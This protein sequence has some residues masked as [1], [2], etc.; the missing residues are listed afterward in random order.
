MAKSR[1]LLMGID[2]G[3]THCKVGLFAPDGAL[4]A[5]ASRPMQPRRDETGAAF[6]DSQDLW[7]AILDAA[8]EAAANAGPHRLTAVGVAG[9]AESGLLVDRHDG[10]PLTGIIPWFDTAA[11]PQAIR[12]AKEAGMQAG[13]VRSGIYPSFKCSLAKLLWLRETHNISFENAVW[14]SVPDWVVYRLT[15]AAATDYSLATRTFAFDINR[16]EWDAAF[17]RRFDLDPSLFPQAQTAGTVAGRISTNEYKR[18]G[19]PKGVPVAVCGHDHVAGAFAVGAVEPGTV[20]DSMG[21]AE[22][23]IGAAPRAPLDQAEFESGLTF[24]SHVA[25]DRNYWMG[26]LSTSGGSVEWLRGLLSDPALTY[27]A[28][29]ALV[30]SAP[31]R[32]TGLLYFPYLAGSGA[33]HSDPLARA[34]FIGISAQTTRAELAR[35]VLEGAA[36]ELEAVRLAAVRATG[37]SIRRIIAAGGGTRNRAWMQIKADVSGVQFEIPAVEETTLL[38]AALLAGLGSG[39]YA[40]EEEALTGPRRTPSRM[41][42]PNP[43]NRTLYQKLFA[44]GYQQLQEP[45]RR[46]YRYRFEES[47]L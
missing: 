21:T 30:E 8:G 28:F 45:L 41:V 14:L 13:F 15:G 36:F 27:D 47:I 31:D 25:R 20:F 42:E 35:A 5:A 4:A 6:F 11:N 10:R 46:F 7:R 44:N 37:Q 2:T 18:S 9:M 39:L 32:P 40:S 19:L 12:L 29:N 26:G 43:E 3:T 23:F 17:L 24:G 34:A 22:A 16:L 38:G 1:A 33:P